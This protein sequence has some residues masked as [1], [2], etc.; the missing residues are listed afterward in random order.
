MGVTLFHV[1]AGRPPFLGETSLGVI[2][3]HQNE[4][5]PALRDL[6]ASVS[7]GVAQIVAKALAKRPEA[8]YADAGEMLLDLERLS[9]GEP[10]GLEVH[11]RVPDA[12]PRT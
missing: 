5:P 9:R 12:D 1:L 6:N 3:M 8:R 10:T 7:D 2:A 4:P 11:P